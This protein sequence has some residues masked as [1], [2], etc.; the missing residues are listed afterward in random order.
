M[1]AHP[2]MSVEEIPSGVLAHIAQDCGISCEDVEDIY[3]CT[4]FQTG[5]LTHATTYVQRLVLSLHH[6]LEID[7]F[8]SALEH[9]ISAS[10]TLRTRFV[11]SELG[12]VQVVVKKGRSPSDRVARYS[13]SDLKS[14]LRQDGSRL[15]HMATPLAWFAVIG[16]KLVATIHH[17]I[18]DHYS[19]KFLV[20]DT[21]SVYQGQKPFFHAPFKKFVEYCHAVDEEE[22][23]AF[24]KSQ[25]RG[26][27]PAIFPSVPPE[28]TPEASRK[29][30]REILLEN[31]SGLAASMPCLLEVAWILTAA[32]YTGSKNVAF[33]YVM[34]G[35]SRALGGL[36]T[37]LGPTIATVPIQVGCLTRYTRPLVDECTNSPFLGEP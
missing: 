4:P 2:V 12:L 29:S 6:S 35:R 21:W 30:S 17:A 33:G 7:R 16:R 37:T 23:V 24:W 8:C 36:E 14:Y 10:E 20:M 3:A 5:I 9:V 26:G 27:T 11:D 25:F 32:D 22:A 18:S 34:S 15:M 28:H 19:L 31:K 13:D 1:A